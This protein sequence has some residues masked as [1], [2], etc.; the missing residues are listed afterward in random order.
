MQHKPNQQ[1]LKKKMNSDSFHCTLK[2]K[3]CW[4]RCQKQRWLSWTQKY[5]KELS[6]M[7]NSSLFQES[8]ENPLWT[9]KSFKK[10]QLFQYKIVLIK[11]NSIRAQAVK[12]HKNFDHF[13]FLRG[14]YSLVFKPEVHVRETIYNWIE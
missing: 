8:I 14:K 5:T 4:L 3:Y 12:L 9:A 10:K 1:G 2:F 13:K 11:V 6:S 7:T